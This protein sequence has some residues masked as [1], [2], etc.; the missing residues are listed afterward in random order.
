MATAVRSSE[1]QRRRA[2]AVYAHAL[3][4]LQGEQYD[5]AE[6]EAWKQLQATL[7]AIER[8]EETPGVSP[9]V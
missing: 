1:E 4:G 5:E 9:A 7:R 2:W 3:Q 6:Q 8:G